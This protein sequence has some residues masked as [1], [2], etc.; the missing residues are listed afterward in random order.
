MRLFAALVFVVPDIGV[1]EDEVVPEFMRAVFRY[2][3]IA[4]SR[5]PPSDGITALAGRTLIGA[6]PQ[7]LTSVA[8]AAHPN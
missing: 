8:Y 2:M 3:L 1:D 6:H 5:S 4:W 7:K